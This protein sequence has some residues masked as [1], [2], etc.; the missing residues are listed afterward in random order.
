[1]LAKVLFWLCAALGVALF[2]CVMY[3]KKQKANATKY[4]V[5]YEESDKMVAG[6]TRT[7]NE[8]RKEEAIKSDNKKEADEK[9]NEMHSGDALANALD[10][11]HKHN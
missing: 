5:K 2:V 10:G 7:I 4:R 1:M 9:I 8:L 3:A 6:L 11:L